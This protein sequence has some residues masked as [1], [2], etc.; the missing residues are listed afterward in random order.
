MSEKSRIFV[1]QN[2]TNNPLNIKIMATKSSIQRQKE[3]ILELLKT[4]NNLHK[5]I[6][7]SPRFTFT[8]EEKSIIIFGV[9]D[10][11]LALHLVLLHRCHNI[12]FYQT[13]VN[14]KNALEAYFV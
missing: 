5:G 1:V 9:T 2:R 8:E 14:H 7:S 3:S 6:S 10:D 4:L 13:K 11:L 12:C